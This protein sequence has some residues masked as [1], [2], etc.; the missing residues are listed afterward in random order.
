[1]MTGLDGGLQRLLERRSKRK[2]WISASYANAPLFSFV[3]IE[4]SVP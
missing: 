4:F 1:M 3:L 2:R